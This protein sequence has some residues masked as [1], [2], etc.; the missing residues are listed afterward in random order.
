MADVKG[1]GIDKKDKQE[2]FEEAA[3]VRHFH[4]PGSLMSFNMEHG[5]SE[6][7][8]RGFKS[9]FLKE[10]EYRQLCQCDNLDDVKLTLGDTD[11]CNVLQNQNKLN[12]EIILNRCRQ[13]NIKEFEFLRSQA[14]GSLATFLNF[15][16]WEHLIKNICFVISGM[17]KGSD[18][19]TLLSKCN[20][21]GYSPH[22]KSVMTFENDTVS[23]GL[24]ELYRTVLVDTPVARYF[25]TY[26][27]SDMK[28][29]QVGRDVQREIQRIYNT[30]EID[31]ITNMLQKLWLEDFYDYS[32]SLGGETAAT[33]KELLE[34][35]AD[36]RAIMI[37]MNSF[38]TFLNEPSN[39]DKERQALYCNFGTLYPEATLN[40]F[41]KV[42]DMQQLGV[43][44]QPYAVYRELWKRATETGR[45]VADL[46]AE[47]EVRLMLLAF[48]GQSHFAA[49][50]AFLK[51]KEREE[52]NL[53]WIVSCINQR[54]DPK[55]T[56][57]W[58]KI[59]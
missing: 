21:L 26:F 36:R 25:E 30:Q 8:L 13:K 52:Y 29:E 4:S 50:Y 51:L 7:L 39:R 33:M 34:F 40:S 28:H 59:L 53:K 55:D 35:E 54:R 42:A 47:Y 32:Q 3:A 44:L 23:D 27:N 17:I 1:G 11:Y 5:F 19:E 14:V 46:L 22:L 31:V 6:A 43:A 45:P 57:R 2:M 48:M 58:I 10:V 38:E 37:T 16:T 20:P 41:N 18:P 24:T 15:V 12:P 9:G 49:F 56:N